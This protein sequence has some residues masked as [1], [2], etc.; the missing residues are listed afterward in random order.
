MRGF[1]EYEINP[2]MLVVNV[3]LLVMLIGFPVAMAM[4]V[5]AIVTGWLSR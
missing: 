5:I 4:F 2:T 3:M 1:E